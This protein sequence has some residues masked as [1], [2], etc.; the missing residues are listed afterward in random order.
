LLALG[1]PLGIVGALAVFE[2]GRGGGVS[3]VATAVARAKKAGGGRIVFPAGTFDMSGFT[4]TLDDAPLTFE[5][6]PGRSVLDFGG[7]TDTAVFLVATSLTMRGL[8]VRNCG[9][10]AVL[11][12]ATPID[13]IAISDCRFLA[14]GGT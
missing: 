13:S 4:A 7:Q 3:A 8:T 2:I 12:T 11:D 5:G 10:I 6:V 1:G 14:V 9:R